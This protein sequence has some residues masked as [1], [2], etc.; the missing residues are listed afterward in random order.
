MIKER[1]CPWGGESGQEPHTG[2]RYR[3]RISLHI[4]GPSVENAFLVPYPEQAAEGVEAAPTNAMGGGGA[5]AQ[6]T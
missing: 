2:A 1:N 4:L 6:G 3:R 5:R